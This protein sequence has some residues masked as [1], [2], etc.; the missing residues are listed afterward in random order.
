MLL[1]DKFDPYFSKKKRILALK[2]IARSAQWFNPTLKITDCRDPEDN[3]FLE[4]AKNCKA[5]AIVTGD[6]DLLALN[7]YQ[8]IRIVTIKEF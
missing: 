5:T 2:A 7:P 4:L 6:Q 1:D 8:G 3:K